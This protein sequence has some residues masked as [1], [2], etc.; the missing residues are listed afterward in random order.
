MDLLILSCEAV[1]LL[2]DFN[3]REVLQESIV[4]TLMCVIHGVT[5][6]S[7]GN[8]L[9]NYMP[10]ITEFTMITTDKARRP[11][12]EYVENS[13]MLLADISQMFPGEKTRLLKTD[14]IKDRA[15]ML[16]SFNKDG[17]LTQTL[18]YLK[19]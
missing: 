8:I 6:P 15:T 12:L 13:L 4:E 19:Q 9:P 16:Q 1:V 5:E 2:S 18:A 11:K 17:R 7:F 14:F 10:Y 3:Y